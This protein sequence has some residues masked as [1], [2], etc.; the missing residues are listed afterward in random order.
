MLRNFA[1]LIA[2]LNHKIAHNLIALRKLSALY[3]ARLAS[4]DNYIN[5]IDIVSAVVGSPVH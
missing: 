1:L 3:N 5:I 4:L 2:A